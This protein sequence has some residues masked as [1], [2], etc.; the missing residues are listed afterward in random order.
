MSVDQDNADQASAVV[1]SARPRPDRR[2]DQ[3][4]DPSATPRA[5]PRPVARWC[6]L[7]AAALLLADAAFQTGLAAG[8]PWGAAAWGGQHTHLPAGMRAASAVSVLVL[9]ALA[10]AVL[11]FGGWRV[12]VA[13]P[14]GWLRA[15]VW[16]VTGFAV[17]NTLANLAS[18]SATEREIMAPATV[19]L[20]VLCGTLARVGA[21]P[22]R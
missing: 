12:P 3:R 4:P 19:V 8:A 10:S 16:A 13:P 17:L 2:P 21:R 14:A 1:P 6:G 18:R 20:A 5:T 7:G 15:T 11:R 9:A 22:G